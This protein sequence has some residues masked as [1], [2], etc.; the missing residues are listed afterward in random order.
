LHVRPLSLLH[1]RPLSLL[2]VRPLSLL[3]VRSVRLR[4]R[5]VMRD[6]T[7]GRLSW[8]AAAAEGRVCVRGLMGSLSAAASWPNAKGQPGAQQYREQPGG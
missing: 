8:R 5:V 7:T 3:H 1:V 6:H 4:G 2:R